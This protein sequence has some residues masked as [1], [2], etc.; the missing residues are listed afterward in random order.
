MSHLWF[1]AYSEQEYIL[2]ILHDTVSEP[3]SC[4]KK[5]RGLLTFKFRCSH[6][7][8]LFS[9]DVVNWTRRDSQSN[10]MVPNAALVGSAMGGQLNADFISLSL[11]RFSASFPCLKHRRQQ[12]RSKEKE[13]FFSWKGPPKWPI[14]HRKD[15]CW[16]NRLA[17]QWTW[18]QFT[19]L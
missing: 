11:P 8:L 17:K 13:W 15:F 1:L 5:Q 14:E 12:R 4:V 18:T 10:L 7:K 19:L 16:G 9:T 6:W 3:F 2:R